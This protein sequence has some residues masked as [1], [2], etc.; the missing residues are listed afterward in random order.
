MSPE[1][2]IGSVDLEMWQS[3]ADPVVLQLAAELLKQT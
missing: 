3:G 2:E 1:R